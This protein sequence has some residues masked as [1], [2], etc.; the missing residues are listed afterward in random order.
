MGKYCTLVF[1]LKQKYIS[2]FY[3][4]HIYITQISNCMVHNQ[5]I[6]YN[7]PNSIRKYLSDFF[8]IFF[9][10]VRLQKRPQIL[11]YR[12]SAPFPKS[13]INTLRLETKWQTFWTTFSNEFVWEK[14]FCI[15]IQNAQKF[16]PKG[17]I[18]K[19]SSLVQVKSWCRIGDEALPEQSWPRCIMP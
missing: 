1:L 13:I 10:A 12:F 7:S 3:D 15:M 18:G 14:I 2:K 8:W 9:L 6:I 19:K 17:T 11:N 16:V 5:L 4:L